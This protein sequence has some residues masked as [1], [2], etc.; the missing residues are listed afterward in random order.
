MDQLT[1]ESIVQTDTEIIKGA[2]VKEIS[3]PEY[4]VY[5]NVE[6]KKDGLISVSAK[7]FLAA[8]IKLTK[9]AKYIKF[10]T[11]NQ[12]IFKEYIESH[13]VTPVVTKENNDTW[14]R[15]PIESLADVMGMIK[16]ISAVYMSVLADFGGERFGCCSRYE[17]CSDAKK[18]IHPDSILSQACAYRRNLEKGKIFYGKNRNID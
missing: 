13:N 18:C 4:T 8:R 10:R 1:L 6:E 15:L 3:N 12:I 7:S 17:Q 16:P 9:K 5:L 11:K 14:T 2:L